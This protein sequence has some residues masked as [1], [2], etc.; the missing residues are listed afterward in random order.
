MVAAPEE[1]DM[2][3]WLVDGKV[4]LS[5]V[6]HSGKSPYFKPERPLIRI[7]FSICLPWRVQ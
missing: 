6:Q 3:A 7:Y 1:E 4:G 2:N 5:F